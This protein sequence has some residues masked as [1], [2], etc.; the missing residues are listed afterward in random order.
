MGFARALLP[1][2]FFLFFFLPKVKIGGFP[3]LFASKF[4][5]SKQVCG[6]DLVCVCVFSS[7]SVCTTSMGNKLVPRL[8]AEALDVSLALPHASDCG[9]NSQSAAGPASG[10]GPQ[11]ATQSCHPITTAAAAAAD[12]TSTTAPIVSNSVCDQLSVP[13]QLREL[14]RSNA[15]VVSQASCTC[16]ARDT[17]PADLRSWRN[18]LFEPRGIVADSATECVYVVDHFR[19]FAIH[20]GRDGTK[21]QCI[22]RPIAGRASFSMIDGPAH[23]SAFYDPRA[24]TLVRQQGQG[25]TT[26]DTKTSQESKVYIA[27][28]ANSA[29]RCV[30]LHQK[31]VH[32]LC[33]HRSRS[34]HNDGPF[35]LASFHYPYGIASRHNG[36]SILVADRNNCSI[37]ELDMTSGTVGTLVYGA[38]EGKPDSSTSTGIV[39][40]AMNCTLDFPGSVAVH[41][42]H[43][44][45]IAIADSYNHCIRMADT[46][47]ER[48]HLVAGSA[49]KDPGFID[50]IGI[51]ARLHSPTALAFH[52]IHHDLLF[53]IDKDNRC[54][55]RLDLRNN[56]VVT[57]VDCVRGI[58]GESMPL[59]VP[60]SLAWHADGKV[61]Y[62]TDFAA[63]VVYACQGTFF[64]VVD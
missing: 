55:R 40:A 11:G 53:F 5:C 4:E 64:F 63:H 9:C 2:L 26:A 16:N 23:E 21:Q 48:V 60:D 6:Q 3:R 51:Q 56:Q 13:E 30:N 22:I 35:K 41:P 14:S 49:S 12:G 17:L 25:G 46:K 31:Q 39:R 62:L 29:I 43:E 59:K 36:T 20:V 33:G 10:P 32:S 15:C 34:G 52:P 50:G 37:R 44:H 18:V 7:L 57:V 38:D 1:V 45:I 27:D 19:L 8:H 28:S 61:L 58:N 47:L 54:V 42:R 24:I